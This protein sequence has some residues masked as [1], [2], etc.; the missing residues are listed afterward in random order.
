A[1]PNTSAGGSTAFAQLL[2]DFAPAQ[3]APLSATASVIDGASAP[4]ASLPAC[5]AAMLPL[6]PSTTIAA[7]STTR[8]PISD[9]A[10]RTTSAPLSTS[11]I[12]AD[13]L[14]GAAITGDG[15]VSVPVAATSSRPA[16]FARA[17]RDSARELLRATGSTDVPAVPNAA[18]DIIAPPPQQT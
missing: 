12:G 18:A 6:S 9:R 15:S 7:G 14:S 13:E 8:S 10:A 5:L 4:A 3:T 2:P 1:Q 16:H 11:L 17:S